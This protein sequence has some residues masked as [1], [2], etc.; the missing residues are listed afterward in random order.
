MPLLLEIVTPERLAYSDTVD[1]VN[2]SFD[3]KGAVC[4]WSYRGFYGE[5]RSEAKC[6]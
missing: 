5:R 1:A 6:P 2:L 3:Q 4:Q